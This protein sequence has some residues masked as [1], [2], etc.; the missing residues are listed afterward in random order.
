MQAAAGETDDG[1]LLE[2]RGSSWWGLPA[3]FVRSRPNQP[4]ASWQKVGYDRSPGVGKIASIFLSIA[5]R[6]QIS[7]KSQAGPVSF[8]LL[9]MY[10]TMS[11]IVDAVKS[12][13]QGF[14]RF[15]FCGSN[16]F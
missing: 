16:A 6:D 15:E 8:D 2:E 10:T 7:T 3:R 1:G 5:T 11:A 9:E 12:L 4:D 13:W 14:F